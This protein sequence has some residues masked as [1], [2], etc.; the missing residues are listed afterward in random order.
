ML[1][2]GLQSYGKIEEVYRQFGIV[3]GFSKSNDFYFDIENILKAL[4]LMCILYI[5]PIAHYLY[6]ESHNIR[7]DFFFTFTVLSGVRDH[8]F[9]PITEEFVYRAAIVAILQ[10]VISEDEIT[11][12]LPCLFGIAHLHHGMHLYYTEGHSFTTSLVH[13]VFQLVYTTVF[14]LLANRIYL[15]SMCNLWSVI[16]VHAMCN[17]LGFPSFEMRTTYPNWFYAY[18]TLLLIGAYLF[19]ILF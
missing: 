8:I 5:G 18:V 3:P 11:K 12:W 16:I 19:W 14:G 4:G 10:P 15:K 6:T 17:I 7:N 13:V 1:T 2:Y 9:A